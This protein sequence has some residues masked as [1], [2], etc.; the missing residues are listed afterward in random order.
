MPLQNDE[1]ARLLLAGAI[2]HATSAAQRHRRI[3]LIWVREHRLQPLQGLDRRGNESSLH[4][5]DLTIFVRPVPAPPRRGRAMDSTPGATMGNP[6]D[7]Y[8]YAR[9]S[10]DGRIEYV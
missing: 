7:A 1:S 5:L 9:I 3:Y 4:Q 6:K 10:P 2:S 8:I